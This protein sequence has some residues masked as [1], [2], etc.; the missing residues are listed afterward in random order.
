MRVSILRSIIISLLS[1]KAYARPTLTYCSDPK[2]WIARPCDT[3]KKILS[4][5]QTSIYK[6]PDLS[7]RP[8]DD[9]RPKAVQA[10]KPKPVVTLKPLATAA[11]TITESPRTPRAWPTID[12]E[13]LEPSTPILELPELERLI[14]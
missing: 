10:P 2:T 6:S 11:T 13:A 5:P 4:S 14:Q 7:Q 9:Q 8:L 1:V 3:S 12:P